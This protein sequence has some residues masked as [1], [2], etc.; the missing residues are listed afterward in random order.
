MSVTYKLENALVLTQFWYDYF[1]FNLTGIKYNYR[2]WNLTLRVC[3][4]QVGKSNKVK[5][6]DYALENI[7]NLK[8]ALPELWESERKTSEV[9]Y[10][11]KI[12]VETSVTA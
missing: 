10:S 5:G 2:V 12:A 9:G 11:A 7:H 4:F 1:W 8:E 6:A 3:R